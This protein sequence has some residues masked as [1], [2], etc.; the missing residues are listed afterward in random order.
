MAT[1]LTLPTVRVSAQPT[2]RILQVGTG[3]R[4]TTITAA[5]A[6][7]GTLTRTQANQVVIEVFP[8]TYTENI[9]LPTFTSIM[10][11]TDGTVGDVVITNLTATATITLPTTTDSFHFIKNLRIINTADTNGVQVITQPAGA[12][13]QTLYIH[14]CSISKTMT[15]ASNGFTYNVINL[16]AHTGITGICHCTIQGTDFA[17]IVNLTINGINADGGVVIVKDCLFNIGLT[18]TTTNGTGN[19]IIATDQVCSIHCEGCTFRLTGNGAGTGTLR[20]I[21]IAVA[22]TVG[23]PHSIISSFFDISGEN[24]TIAVLVNNA[25][26]TAMVTGC[27]FACI[28]GVASNTGVNGTVCTAV[29]CSANVVDVAVTPTPYVGANVVTAVYAGRIRPD[30][31]YLTNAGA[32]GITQVVLT[33]DGNNVDNT[34]TYENGILVAYV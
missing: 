21:N 32:A 22:Q 14:N 13:T 5:I 2:A 8:G 17:A 29:I 25:G 26:A 20:G 19:G 16:G 9:T 4:Y 3:C 11:R 10:G 30:G 33:R 27:I 15:A 18:N 28:N 6:G 34:M 24:A 1:A 31:Q 12:Y 23:D 7:A